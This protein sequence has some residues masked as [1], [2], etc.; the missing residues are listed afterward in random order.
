MKDLIIEEWLNSSTERSPDPAYLDYHVVVEISGCKGHS[1]RISFWAMLKN[2]RI[3]QYVNRV[4]GKEAWNSIK[5]FGRQDSFTSV[6]TQ[7]TTQQKEV[8]KCIINRVLRNVMRTGVFDG[9][10]QVWDMSSRDGDCGTNG[11]KVEAAWHSM[12]KDSESC[13]TFAVMTDLCVDFNVRHDNSSPL[14]ANQ[15]SSF[16]SKPINT[17][18]YTRICI[19][20]HRTLDAGRCSEVKHSQLSVDFDMDDDADHLAGLELDSITNSVDDFAI[21]SGEPYQLGKLS[22]NYFSTQ[23]SSSSA[24]VAAHDVNVNLQRYDNSPQGYSSVG[25]NDGL[26]RLRARM[27]DRFAEG[28][29]LYRPLNRQEGSLLQPDTV[30]SRP[31]RSPQGVS[32]AEKR[33]VAT[34]E[35][36]A[37]VNLSS[38]SCPQTPSTQSGNLLLMSGNR[39]VFCD[40]NERCLGTLHLKP[41]RRDTEINLDEASEQNTIMAKW[42]PVNQWKSKLMSVQMRLEEFDEKLQGALYPKTDHGDI[43]W[44]ATCT[45]LIKANLDTH[46]RVIYTCIE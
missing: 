20:I 3:M 29:P 12:V 14:E 15:S 7:M 40:E 16:M 33:K 11:R 10:L 28:G 9:R 31:I 46:Q 38:T 6:W 36:C 25:L 26:N 5:N 27:E 17:I 8:M 41:G 4:I 37:T 21:D 13:A 22:G 19:N 35:R 43:I 34:R 23:E 39:L 24:R 30:L 45:E 32:P 2:R 42:R 44:R 1:R 18:L